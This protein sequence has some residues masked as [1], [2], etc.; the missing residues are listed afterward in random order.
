MVRALAKAISKPIQMAGIEVVDAG[1]RGEIATIRSHAV[2]GFHV[3]T[4]QCD[5]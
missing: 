5:A 4:G 1:E 2:Y 3:F